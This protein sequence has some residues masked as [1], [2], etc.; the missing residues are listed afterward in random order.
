MPEKKKL[1]LSEKEKQLLEKIEKSKKELSSLRNRRKLEIGELAYKHGL[2][3]FD[4]TQLGEAF[5]KLA[6]ELA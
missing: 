6:T 3:D 2:G 4:N 5:A 1:S